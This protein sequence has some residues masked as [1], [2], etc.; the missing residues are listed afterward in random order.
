MVNTPGVS[1]LSRWTRQGG[2][3]CTVLTNGLACG[4]HVYLL[5]DKQCLPSLAAPDIGSWVLP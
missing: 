2:I 1:L 5:A 3:K 4:H